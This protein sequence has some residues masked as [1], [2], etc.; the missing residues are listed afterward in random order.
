MKN[1][2]IHLSSIACFWATLLFL[3]SNVIGQNTASLSGHVLSDESGERVSQAEIALQPGNMGTTTNTKGRFSFTNLAPGNYT[4]T[5]SHLGCIS[6]TREFELAAGE[7]KHL[8]ITLE[9]EVKLLEGI[10]ITELA[11][12]IDPY[13]KEVVKKD[14]IAKL[15]ARDIGDFLRMEPNV[16][17]IRKG[18]GN[19]DPVVRGLKFGQLNVQTNGGQKIEGGCPNR[20]D[21]AASH[22]DIND[23]TYIEILKGPYALRYGPNFGAV[24]N[25]VTEKAQPFESWKIKARAIKGWESNWNG[26][27]EHVSISGGNDRIF[28]ALSGNNQNYGNYEDGNGNEVKSEFRKYNFS[29]ELGF[30]PAENHEIR[31]AYK[32]SQGRD[33]RFPTLPMDERSDDTQLYSATYHYTNGKSILKTIDAKAY[34]SDVNHE[35]DNKWRSFSDT[36]VAISTIEAKNT[37]GRADFGFEQGISTLHAGVDYEDIRKDGQRV[38]NMIMQPGLP[39]KTEDLWNDA[40]IQNLG[41]FA[42]YKL[43]QNPFLNWI[44]AARLDINKAGSNPLVLKNMMGNEMYRNDT[45]DSDFTNLSLSGGLSYKITSELTLDFALGRGVRSPD[46]VE[47]FIILLP[48]GYDNYD[49]LG[50][51]LLKPENNHQIDLT[52]KY[53][54]DRS[55]SFRMNGF[56][57]YIT[58]YITGIKLPPSQV[59]PQSKGV[60]GVKQF[61]NIDEAFMYGFEFIWISPARFNWGINLSAAYTAGYNPEAIKYV[62]ENGEVINQETVKN[63]PL[64]E[65]PPFEA[66]LRFDYDFFDGDLVPQISLRAVADQKRISEAFDE[67]E[68][69]GFLVAGFNLNYQINKTISL[70]GGVNNIFDEAYY[71]HLN[72]RIIGSETSLYEPGRSFYLNV[73]LNL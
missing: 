70:A 47:R 41:I 7:Q 1:Y 39:V 68:T 2:K 64:P 51:P 34:F 72:R 62:Y 35:M 50:N 53:V 13:I 37:G 30:V 15:P 22:I 65:I 38:K 59:M 73:I 3:T 54:C 26:T 8:E 61:Q 19:I 58:D 36:V 11:F 27:K 42:E 46:M 14:Q 25:L 31:L 24:L 6:Q 44:F 45:V 69:P 66:N 56:Y 12:N 28:F 43:E 21:P 10:E 17:G 49:Y 18:G 4:L 32:N 16:S 48:V 63:D 55:G 29:A 52:L 20:M 33:I 71:E 40:S 23:I 5:V 67:K 60:L 9:P 57:S